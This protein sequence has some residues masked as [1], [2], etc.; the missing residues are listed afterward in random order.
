MVGAT[1]ATIG[2]KMWHRCGFLHYLLHE[3]NTTD[4]RRRLK[5]IPVGWARHET[6]HRQHRKPLKAGFRKRS[7]Y[8]MTPNWHDAEYL[9]SL[10]AMPR[11]KTDKRTAPRC[12]VRQQAP[13]STDRR[14]VRSRNADARPLARRRTSHLITAP[15]QGSASAHRDQLIGP[16]P[17][18]RRDRHGLWA[19]HRRSHGE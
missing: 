2:V 10:E 5:A 19:S 6:Q 8:S 16:A 17:F 1:F 4:C 11:L 3:S 9:H 13:R 18:P 14:T 15:G 7:A 12:S